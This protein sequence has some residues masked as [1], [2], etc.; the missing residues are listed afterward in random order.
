MKG[1]SVDQ[2][3]RRRIKKTC[4]GGLN[5]FLI[6]ATFESPAGGGITGRIGS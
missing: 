5:P 2:G 6:R 3:G 4:S 1:K